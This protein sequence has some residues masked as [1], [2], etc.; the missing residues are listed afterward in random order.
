MNLMNLLLALAVT[1]AGAAVSFQSAANASLSARIGLGASLIINTVIVL[2][3]T[4][5]FYFATRSTAATFFPAGTPWILY[6]GGFCGFSIILAAAYVFPRIGAGRAI[7]LMVLG[8]GA[9]ALAID[10]FGFMGLSRAP[11]SLSRIGGFMLIVAG[12]ALVRR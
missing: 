12:V 9:A 7:A 8:Q 3:C 4:F 1:F 11:I 5:V 10:H 2:L 6:I